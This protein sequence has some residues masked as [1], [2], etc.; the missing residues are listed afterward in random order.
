MARSP[1]FGRRMPLHG[2]MKPLK[3]L[4]HLKRRPPELKSA[5]ETLARAKGKLERLTT[6]VAECESA[7]ADLRE[8]QERLNVEAAKVEAV[9]DRAAARIRAFHEDLR[10]DN[11]GPVHAT[12][13]RFGKF[14]SMRAAIRH[15]LESAGPAWT[16]TDDIAEFLK[17]QGD[18]LFLNGKQESEWQH[19]FVGS[20]LRKMKKDGT[21]ERQPM[22]SGS[23][24][25]V[26]RMARG[27]QPVNLADLRAYAQQ[28]GATTADANP[29]CRGRDS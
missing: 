16:S 23:L 3:S 26:W 1:S 14:R 8:R 29:G 12:L 6:A 19:D 11:T 10:P 4:A 24:Q 15:L 22:P 25:V 28:K 9:R 17:Q 2:G 27:R 5:V 13:G 21:V 7:I 20:A 18:L